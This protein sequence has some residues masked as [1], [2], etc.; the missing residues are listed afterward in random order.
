MGIQQV[1]IDP[2]GANVKLDNGSWRRIFGPISDQTGL[3][4]NRVIAVDF[5]IEATDIDTLQSRYR[6]TYEQF[7]SQKNKKFVATLDDELASPLVS[8]EPGDG[9][10]TATFS[11]LA[12]NDRLAKTATSIGM[13]LL[14][15]AE[16][17]E[18]LPDILG[19]AA[20]VEGMTV[21]T[22]FN[23]A[24][25]RSITVN[26]IFV[27]DE[28]GSAQTN[29]DAIKDTI[30]TDQL[31]VETTGARNAASK[32]VLTSE[33]L[34]DPE[35]Q[36]RRIEAE[37]RS[38]R[39]AFATTNTAEARSFAVGI[40]T[41]QPD[42]WSL[43][44]QAGNRPLLIHASGS[45]HL[46]HD[47]LSRGVLE[48]KANVEAD[49]KAAI[50]QEIGR[51]PELKA[52]TSSFSSDADQGLLTFDI[53][54]QADNTTVITY[55][56]THSIEISPD[57]AIAGDSSGF[58][59]R[60]ESPTSPDVMHTITVERMGVGQLGREGLSRPPDSRVIVNRSL[61]NTDSKYDTSS[62]L[63]TDF[64][65]AIF[66]ERLQESFLELNFEEG[67]RDLLNPVGEQGSG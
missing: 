2:A 25:D 67:T 29:L 32:Q 46:S 19:D 31:L 40:E 33:I 23:A 55:S 64:G 50:N 57:A 51:S 11:V 26:A 62:S 54:Y 35:G 3:D 60:Q 45:V 24:R 22:T 59:H 16:P 36:G 1:T 18:L 58:I 38:E 49:V 27:T 56:R 47:L 13:S 61:V 28:S 39:D 34:V 8:L 65:F 41:T 9:T 17:I 20:G 14:I 42:E 21:T 52:L 5:L 43:D 63:E 44:S 48:A 30:F 53:V 12:D 37:W 66:R 7:N 10:Y 15:V 4:G 6:L